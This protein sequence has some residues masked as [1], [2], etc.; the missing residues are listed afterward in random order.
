M[1]EHYFEGASIIFEFIGGPNDGKC[2]C[3]DST[4]ESEAT[5]ARRLAWCFGMGKAVAEKQESMTG[6]FGTY[7]QPSPVIAERAN[8]DRWSQAQRDALMPYYE[9][10]VTRYEWQDDH[11][12]ITARYTGFSDIQI[13]KET[14]NKVERRA[15]A[16]QK[17]RNRFVTSVH[18]AK[19]HPY[20]YIVDF[21]P[22]GVERE[23][24]D[25]GDPK[26]VESCSALVRIPDEGPWQLNWIN[27]IPSDPEAN[28]EDFESFAKELVQ[29]ER[30]D[31]ATTDSPIC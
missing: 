17:I 26:R 3:S 19:D 2:I 12:L 20:V 7:R 29:N 28:Q 6:D 4:D 10:T 18:P 15:A 25:S 9:Y 21:T 1:N 16:R 27:H 30:R 8:A 11:L 14:W 31:K 5:T 23:R 22:L 24:G 13:S